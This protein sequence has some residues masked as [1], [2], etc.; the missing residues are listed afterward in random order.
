MVAFLALALLAL[1][2]RCVPTSSFALQSSL[3]ARGTDARVL[4]RQYARRTRS[5][6]I[7]HGGA[8]L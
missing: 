5:A 8:W 6:Q 4:V 1:D 7:P 2:A 3:P